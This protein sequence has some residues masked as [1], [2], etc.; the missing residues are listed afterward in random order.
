VN[1]VRAMVWK[2]VAELLGSRRFLWVFMA[3]V[4][5]MGVLPALSFAR[6]GERAIAVVGVLFLVLYVLFAA[7]IVVANT[8][9]DLVLH[10]RVG[11]TLEYLLTTPLSVRAIFGA[12]IAVA[13]FVG[14]VAS[15]LSLGVQLVAVAM[16]SGKG[17][18]W[19]FLAQADGRAIAFGVTAGLSLY[20]AVV[21]TFVA[22]R[23]GEQR[24]AYM[25]TVF[26]VGLLIV[27]FIAGGL[28]V[29]LTVN[30]V[31]HAALWL[32]VIAVGLAALGLRIFQREMLVLYLQE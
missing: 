23:I 15:M 30:W 19:L 32:G 24:A 11:H 12:K 20:V 1:D 26:S 31:S 4:L 21:G 22:L 8:A 14:Y 16:L 17:L 29:H 9:P 25:V 7:V 13:A 5:G 2:E 3:A 10:E 27:P 28:H 6:Q 18:H